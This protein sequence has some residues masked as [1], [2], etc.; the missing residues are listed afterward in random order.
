MSQC[1]NI[2]EYNCDPTD[3]RLVQCG[4]CMKRR[5]PA[6]DIG[7]PTDIGILRRRTS[8]LAEGSPNAYAVVLFT[9]FMSLSLSSG[10]G[11]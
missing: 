2:R 10:A 8:R 1:A 11:I 6:D 5:M 4:S 9:V 7:S 3:K